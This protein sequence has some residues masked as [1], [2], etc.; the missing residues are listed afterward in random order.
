VREWL[1]PD[2]DGDPVAV[3]KFRAAVMQNVIV[4]AVRDHKNMEGVPQEE[5]ARR[6]FRSDAAKMWNARLC[7]RA[8]LTAQDMVTL[9]MVLPGAMPDESSIRRFVGVAEGTEA[10]PQ[11]WNFP[12]SSRAF[13]GPPRQHR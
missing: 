11:F 8:N 9:M 7:G 5:L 1:P 2:P 13:E 3:S 12:D 4:L 10:R 6:D